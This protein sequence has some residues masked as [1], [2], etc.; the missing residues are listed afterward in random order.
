MF[1]G[2]IQSVGTIVSSCEK[3]GDRVLAIHTG[4][5]NLDDV[6]IGDSISVNGVCLTV[7]STSENSFTADVSAETLRHTTLG[8]LEAES[9]LNLEKAITA[10]TRLGGHFVTGHVDGVG[11]ILQ[12][13][14][15][16][17]SVFYRISVPDTLAKYIAKKGSICIDGISLTVNEVNGN[18]VDV[19]IVPHTLD[20][21]NIGAIYS[22]SKV[23]IEV[24]IIARYLER[25]ML[26]EQ[27]ADKSGSSITMEMLVKSGFV[28]S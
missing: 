7:I 26:G 8:D 15:E 10:S 17:R 21:T 5:M 24:D 18:E 28:S 23:N 22:G 9:L 1:T 20:A 14:E 16:A 12:R 11:S 2:I 13:R 4:S 6:E 25:L 3:E 27:A 19:N